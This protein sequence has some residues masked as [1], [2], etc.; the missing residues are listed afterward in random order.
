M[1]ELWNN[2]ENLSKFEKKIEKLSNFEITSKL[3]DI[4]ITSKI[5]QNYNSQYKENVLK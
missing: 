3:I 2:I 5:V 4:T 1:F